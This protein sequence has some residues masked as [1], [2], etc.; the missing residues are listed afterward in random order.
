[1]W[2]VG[3]TLPRPAIE[4]ILVNNKTQIVLKLLTMYFSNWIITQLLVQSNS[5][6]TNSLGPLTGHFKFVITR[7]ISALSALKLRILRKKICSV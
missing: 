3:R 6:I 4:D 5:V 1:M 7:L 2:P